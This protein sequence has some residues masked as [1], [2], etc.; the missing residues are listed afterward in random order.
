ML[1]P[2]VPI[3]VKWRKRTAIDPDLEPARAGA[4]SNAF[5]RTDASVGQNR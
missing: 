5:V 1:M 2:K 3:G 4:R